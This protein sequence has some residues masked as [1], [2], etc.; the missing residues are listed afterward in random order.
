[1]S[2]NIDIKIKAK[3]EGVSEIKKLESQLDAMGRI[4]AF[5]KLKKDLEASREA[6][7]K[8]QA[9]VAGLAREMAAADKP[10]KVLSRQFK[11]ARKEAANLKAQF[12][13]NQKSLHTLRGSLKDAGVNTKNLAAEQKRL[14]ASLD[15]T[16]DAAAREAR[17]G[18][19]RNM[20]HLKSFRSIH[21]EIAATREAYVRLKKSGT[22]SMAELYKAKLN[23]K[24]QIAALKNETNGWAAVISRAQAG[25]AALAGLGYAAVKSVSG[26]SEFSQRMAE[27]NTLLDVSRGRFSALSKEILDMSVRIPQT[28]S[29][30]AAA[31]YD[32]VSAGVALEN[33]TTVLE[34]S[35]KAAVAGVTDTKTAVNAGVG[36][37]NAYGKDISEL[38]KVYDVL[39]Q[40]VKSGVTTFPALSQYIGEVLPSARAAGV[41]FE[42]VAASIAA[43]TKSGIRTPQAA[44]AMK[45]AI[46]AMAAPTPEA[47]KQFDAL[48]ITWKGLI[49]TLEAIKA[50]GLSVDQMRFLIPDVDARTGV[51]ALTQ[52]MEGLKEILKGMKGPAGAM[53]E[54]FDKMKDTP[55]NQI[56]LFKNEISKLSIE[57]GGF[58]SKGVLPV[59]KGIRWVIDS[60][61]K[62]DTVTKI[63][64]TTMGLAGSGFMLWKTGLRAIALGLKGMV[65][66]A[67]AAVAGL[68][69][70]AAS[71]ALAGAAL[72][73]GLVGLTIFAG[74]EAAKAG[75]AFAGL[76]KA[77][78]HAKASLDNLYKITDKVME[79]YEAFK[80]VKLPDDITG[81]APEELEALSRNL[82]RA[83]AY[84]VALSEKL[85]AR[86]DDTTIFGTVSREAL[87]AR[88][89]LK[90]VNQ[91]IG[92][93]D[94]GL[95]QIEQSGRAA[96]QGM[97]VPTE[98]VKATGEQLN[99]FEK[100]AKQAYTYAADQA[101]KYA[102]AVL[103]WE[104]KIKYARMSTEDKVRELGRKGLSDEARWNDEKRQADEKLYAARAALR[105][106][107]YKL[108]E[109]LA[110]D[111][112]TLYAGLAQEVKGSD[113]SGS[114][115]VKQSLEETKK[116]AVK[117]VKTV[118]T[119]IQDL[120]ARQ[121]QNAR[122][123]QTQ[124]QATAEEIQAQLD[125]IARDRHA[126]VHITLKDL[127]AAQN[128]INALTAPA[129]KY[130]TVVT[131]QVSENQTG[132]PVLAAAGGAFVRRAG[133]LGGYGGGDRIRSLLEAGEFVV[134]KEAVAKYGRSFFN[135]LNAMRLQMPDLQGAVRARIGGLISSLP[136]PGVQAP[137]FGAGGGVERPAETLLVRFQ[138]G[139]MEAPVKITDPS[140]REAMKKMA[141][142]MSRMRLIYGR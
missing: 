45:G 103:A 18:A 3:T 128:K 107:D 26:F 36:V 40:T 84:W 47:K 20:L 90:Q 27:V 99:T 83:R 95:K 62:V 15:E 8:A 53:N 72:K 111:A 127:E 125:E 85:R 88:A 123:S 76:W 94:T 124:W 22:L 134:R 101:R 30:L 5:R 64:I 141:R 112:E 29:E 28:A 71:S 133:A 116:V 121:K 21:Q 100:Q 89:Q 16:R 34:L 57:I 142:Q 136:A 108:A 38:G 86:G 58:L 37:I 113:S 104:E 55:E 73:T 24:N 33:S 48:G 130:I 25:L 74:Y 61:A 42:D 67:H 122:D 80:D 118:G 31:E 49:P 10:S 78:Q 117:G 87:A 19:A 93:I 96:G 32:I 50:K 120:Y 109:K 135:A 4:D 97:A 82:K 13:K 11:T 110:R 81:K 17:I 102:E 77:V 52:N 23:M 114:E 43:M 137:A 14:K 6:W 140:S 63:L 35:A 132:G 60:I 69:T 2:S 119:F 1:M 56:R 106:N 115:V 75:K 98:A 68:N 66:Q 79:K 92:E 9:G 12:E 51:L 138:A 7:E 54:A 126:N 105:E 70:F 59:L 39:F 44:T 65:V 46:N 131:R 129:R 41:A 139:E 91:R